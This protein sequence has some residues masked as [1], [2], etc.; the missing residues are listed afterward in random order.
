VGLDFVHVNGRSGRFYIVEVVGSGAALFDYD[1][2]GDLDL[3]LVQGGSLDERGGARPS[4]RL[5]R[6]DLEV[7]PSGERRLRFTDV[8]AAAGIESTAYGMGVAVGDVDG[9]G[10]PDLYVTDFGPNRLLRNRGDGTFEDVT[11]ASGTD[12][13][14]WSVPAVFFDYDGD[15][16][17]DLYVGNYV[18]FTLATHKVCISETGAQ[19]YCGPLSYHPETDRLFRNRGDG[20][21]EDVSAASGVGAAA[22]A[23][24]GAQAADFDGDGL[25]DLYVAND[26]SE[27]FLWHNRGDGTFSDEALLAGCA[28]NGEGKA[29][30]SMGVDAADFDGDGDL[31]LFVTNLTRESNTLWVNEGGGLFRDATVPSGLD[32][33]SWPYTGFGAAWLDYDNDG[34]LDLAVVN[35]AV[36][37]IPELARQG[38]PFPLH[39]PNQLF[40]QTADGRFEDVT[41]AAGPA[42]ALS[43]VSR[44][45]AFG[46]VDNDGDT[47]VVVV[48]NGGPVRLLL[49]RVGQDRPWLGLRLVAGEPPRDAIGAQVAVVRRGAP[50]LRR[51]VRTDGSYASASDPRVLVGLGEGAD[52]ERLEV[53]W[54][55]GAE[56]V[57]EPPPLGRYTTLRRGTG[58]AIRPPTR[59]A[60]PNPHPP[61]SNPPAAGPP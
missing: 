58:K 12:D 22:G 53:T 8:T 30:A 54:P 61:P 36:Y 32:A 6:N 29:E 48:N 59:P 26:Q 47:D 41:A 51:R 33:P 2:D 55:D 7:L 19:D 56:E 10:R 15:G 37:V 28:L 49:N 18:D 57:F 4:D 24:L 20:T 9:D 39:Q 25:P 17:D 50:T 1:G 34:R 21:F 13:P 3:F 44:G 27:N 52:V 46:D 23:T 40:R 16:D 14:R 42:F 38:D 43:K 11:A 5:Y 60:P 45:A 31:D 35:G